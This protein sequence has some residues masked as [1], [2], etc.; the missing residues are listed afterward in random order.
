MHF[1]S[2]SCVVLEISLF[3]FSNGRRGPTLCGAH[4]NLPSLRCLAMFC[5]HMSPQISSHFWSLDSGAAKLVGIQ[6]WW[7]LQNWWEC[8]T[9]GNLKLTGMQNWW[10]CKTGG[11]VKQAECKIGGNLK[12]VG[13]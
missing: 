2:E 10:E 6:N 1:V 3:G 11:N 5:T 12:L 7:E 13:I 9:G 8:K 4:N